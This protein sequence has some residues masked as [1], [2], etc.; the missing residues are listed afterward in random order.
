[1]LE[2]GF[3][4]ADGLVGMGGVHLETLLEMAASDLNLNVET[5][6]STYYRHKNERAIFNIKH[7]FRQ[8]LSDRQELVPMLFSNDLFSSLYL[9][10]S[11]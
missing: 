9:I 5:V 1:M 2:A 4:S 3:T 10:I 8:I 7:H 6:R 11:L